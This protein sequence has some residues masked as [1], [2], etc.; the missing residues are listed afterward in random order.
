MGALY[1]A[2]GSTQQATNFY[3]Q[4]LLLVQQ[5]LPDLHAREDRKKEAY[6]LYYLSLIHQALGSAK[7]A[8]DDC[9]RALTLFQALH[10]GV[11]L[12]IVSIRIEEL[13]QDLKEKN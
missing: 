9:N 13:S 10:D 3:R 4:A 8:L 11:M 6:A 7:D 12:D 5:A 2:S 1:S